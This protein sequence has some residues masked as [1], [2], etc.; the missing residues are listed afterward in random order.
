MYV[1]FLC[2]PP[3]FLH[4][5]YLAYQSSFVLSSFRFWW[6]VHSQ[7]SFKIYAYFH[8]FLCHTFWIHYIFSGCSPVRLSQV[9]QLYTKLLSSTNCFLRKLILND[10]CLRTWI[11]L[12]LHVSL[13]QTDSSCK[14]IQL[15]IWCKQERN[16]IH[17]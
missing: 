2:R 1:C 15:N 12:P 9:G 5:C 16:K 6:T 8:Y 13:S 10:T 7:M 3:A 4:S 17:P 11:F 14:L